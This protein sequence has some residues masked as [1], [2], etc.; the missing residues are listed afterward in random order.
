MKPFIAITASAICL[1]TSALAQDIQVEVVS[2]NGNDAGLGTV[3]I[4]TIEF[5]VSNHTGVDIGL[6]LNVL[7]SYKAGS[8]SEMVAP[9]GTSFGRKNEVGFYALPAGEAMLNDVGILGAICD[10]IEALELVPLCQE[11]DGTNCNDAIMVLPNSVVATRL[12]GGTMVGGPEVVAFSGPVGPL[13][14]LIMV[15]TAGGVPLMTLDMFQPEGES[16]NGT[17]LAT[18]AICA[19]AGLSAGC[20]LAG[21]EGETEF[22]RVRND[23]QAS[24]GTRLS[25]TDQGRLSFHWDLGTGAGFMRNLAGTVNLPI[26]VEIMP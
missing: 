1:A 2:L 24:M 16:A 26:M 3:D 17:Y 14:G 12:Q 7:P 11:A 10:E 18:E 6:G 4:C 19:A 9:A 20:D 13:H 23:T 15:S 22:G 8:F 25:N 5:N 21:I